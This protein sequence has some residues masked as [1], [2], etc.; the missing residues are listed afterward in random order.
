MKIRRI[1]WLAFAV[2]FI[3]VAV[4]ISPA[5]GA[6]PQPLNLSYGLSI[7][8]IA[9]LVV[10]TVSVI[11]YALSIMINNPNAAAWMKNQIFEGIL[12]LALLVAFSSMAYVFF[13]NPQNGYSAIGL[14]P[15][16]CKSSS[17]IFELGE[18]DMSTFNSYASSL[19]DISL[20]A[21]YLVGLSPGVSIS[22]SLGSLPNPAFQFSVGGSTKLGSIFPTDA[23]LPITVVISALLLAML[24]S[25]T[26]AIILSL[27]IFFLLVFITLG[28]VA[29]IF[30][31]SRSFAGI[32][33]SMGIGLGLVYP[34]MASITYGF[35][36]VSMST[37]FSS[38]LTNLPLIITAL[39]AYIATSIG[40]G[41]GS[42][43]VL[44]AAAFLNGG[45]GG[46]LSFIIQA[47]KAVG[48]IILGLTI[49]PML[50]FIVLETFITDFSAAIG[51][52]VTF[53]VLL[54]GLI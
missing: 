21:S 51:E 36:I 14:L 39:L 6:V 41:A 15:S 17:N 3:A 34:L 16:Q 18:C 27:S 43:T 47:F 50:N 10:I 37:A 20:S 7:A 9:L 48:Y 31:F 19:V 46:T 32:L 13:I 54:S 40:A 44:G 45:A 30:G 4:L 5:A 11:A 8:A 1:E 23:F 25:Y 33:I 35:I 52:K 22:A 38:L 53:L 42:A 24:V 28:L 49:I 2:S 29:R 26:Q 12:S